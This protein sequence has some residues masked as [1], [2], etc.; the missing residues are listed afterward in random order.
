MEESSS[1]HCWKRR[2]WKS[3]WSMCCPNKIKIFA[4]RSC[5]EIL[6]TKVAL[7]QRKIIQEDYCPMCFK[8]RESCFHAIW[9]CKKVRNSWKDV[10]KDDWAVI[11][12]KLAGCASVVDV[13]SVLLEWAGPVDME[14]FWVTAWSLWNRRNDVVM[15]GMARGSESVFE[16]AS[17]W[18]EEW[19]QANA[20]SASSQVH[21]AVHWTPP[22]RDHVKVNFDGAVSS[23]NPKARV[24]VVIRNNV[25]K[26][27]TVAVNSFE[28]V[29]SATLVEAM[30]AR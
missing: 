2:V 5:K 7:M 30:A 22:P 8:S 1:G 13:V 28:G 16:K 18:Y 20:R 21:L 4:W 29:F 27:M 6:Q 15:R 19:M 26:V 3:I 23:T 9:Q 11:A 17:E 14:L 12:D 24:G 25:G 10:F